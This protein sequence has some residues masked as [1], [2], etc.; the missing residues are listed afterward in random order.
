MF[1]QM[2]KKA[3]V[4]VFVALV[5]L[6]CG[7]YQ[8]LLKSNDS[9]EKYVAAQK[10]YEEGVEEESKPKLRRALRLFEQIIEEYRGKPQGEKLS[11]LFADTY[12]QLGDD[13]LASYQ[14]ERFQQTYP[15]SEKL[16]EATFK[17]AESYYQLSPR[18]DLDQ[19]DT[20][21]AVTEL[22]NYLDAFPDGEYA[23]KANEYAAELREKLEK[24]AFEIAKQYHKTGLARSGNLRAAITSFDNF[25]KE[26]PGSTFRE[27]AYYY[28]F[29]SAYIL[30]V[31]SYAALT[32]ERLKEAKE[33]YESYRKR[34][35]EGEYLETMES[36]IEDIE[37]RLQNS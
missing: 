32:E 19:T 31:N 37:T 29:D 33:Y 1:L 13:Y 23:D 21:K 10:Y 8:E 4:L 22:Q 20:D 14:F 35:P 15:N 12:Y 11:F 26:Y 5:S 3:V 16:E 28:R 34:Y 30:A 36:S 7:E 9:G 25:I 6:S 24:K 27:A 18:Y 2:M 17:K